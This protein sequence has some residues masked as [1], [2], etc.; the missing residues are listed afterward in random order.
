MEEK[1]VCL[2]ATLEKLATFH[3]QRFILLFLFR[4]AG[5][6]KTTLENLT[7][8]LTP[9]DVQLLLTVVK[10]NLLKLSGDCSK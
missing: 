10:N 5:R 9:G 8:S 7:M 2:L 6:V 4:E 3:P 1:N